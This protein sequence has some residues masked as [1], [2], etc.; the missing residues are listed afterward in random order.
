MR[1]T[2]DEIEA[3]GVKKAKEKVEKAEILVY[4]VDAA[5]ENFSED[6]EMIKS[7]IRDDLK[8]IICATKI[9]E[10]IPTH[11]EKIEQIFRNE[12][13]DAFDFITISAL[14]LSILA[15][16]L[17]NT[18]LGAIASIIV[19]YTITKDKNKKLLN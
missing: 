12:I 15:S 2:T 7:L 17:T 11:Y 4:L 3:I 13:A 6:I 19:L 14:V 18:F 8:L 1:E 5:T 9:D 16:M 10:V